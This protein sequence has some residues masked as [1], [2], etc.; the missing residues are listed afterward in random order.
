MTAASKSYG[1]S[2][3]LG[4]RVLGS[5]FVF[6]VISNVCVLDV[7]KP[8]DLFYMTQQQQ[9]LIWLS[10]EYVVSE[11]VNTEILLL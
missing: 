11:N 7:N 10:C 8:Y 5:I 9:A 6:S 1:G 4:Y 2:L 3:H